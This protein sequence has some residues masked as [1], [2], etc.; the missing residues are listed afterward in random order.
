MSQLEINGVQT[1]INS[2]LSTWRELLAELETTRLR[3]GQV[4][5]SVEFDGDEVLQFREEDVLLRPLRG[6]GQIRVAA[7]EMKQLALS[8]VEDT[9]RYLQ[10]LELSIVDV[11]ECFRNGLLDQANM[12]LQRV[13]EGM[14]LLVAI[15]RGIELSL[16]AAPNSTSGVATGIEQMKPAV[17]G[18]IEAQTTKDWALLADLLEYELTASVSSFEPIIA[19]FRTRLQSGI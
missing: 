13:L 5:A 6:I 19:E 16:D 10:S 8:A 15:L 2:G 1:T 9:T 3:P 11:A 7:V 4:I 14:K 18:V 12:K 17:E